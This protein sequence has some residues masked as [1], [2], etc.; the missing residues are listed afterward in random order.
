MVGMNR[1]K[2]F[3]FSSFPAVEC[4]RFTSVSRLWGI[5]PDAFR[6][7]TCTFLFSS[8]NVTTTVSKLDKLLLCNCFFY[9]CNDLFFFLFPS[10]PIVN[11]N[12]NSGQQ[13]SAAARLSPHS[14]AGI[15]SFSHPQPLS[16]RVTQVRIKSRLI[17]LGVL[18]AY[19]VVSFVFL[20]FIFI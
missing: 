11:N 12:F 7:P 15:L 17:R 2:I 20:S 4:T 14:S 18:N 13:V 10:S 8:F 5:R 19:C 1:K 9:L 6:S 16:P 3:Y